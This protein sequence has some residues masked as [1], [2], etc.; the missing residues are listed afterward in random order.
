MIFKIYRFF[1]ELNMDKKLNIERV[2][3]VLCEF[4]VYIII[5]CYLVLYGF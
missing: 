4:E 3:L 5:G 2:C 1:K